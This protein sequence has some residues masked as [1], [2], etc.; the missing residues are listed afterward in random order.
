MTGEPRHASVAYPGGLRA[1]YR[2]AGSGQAAAVFALSEAGGQLVDHGRLAG[3]EPDR[4][5]RAELRVEGPTGT[6]MARLASPIYDEPSAVLWDTAGQLVV[7]Y[8]FLAYGFAARSGALM[9]SHRSGTPL[10]AVL[11]SSRLDHVLV[12]SEIDTLALEAAGTVL[13]RVAHSDVVSDARLIGGRLVLTSYGGAIATLD[14]NTGR[15]VG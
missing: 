12:Q 3:P 5:C 4:L 1:R 13:W 15:P 8:G 10:V 7:K 11:A 2:W 9:W 14:P 6:W